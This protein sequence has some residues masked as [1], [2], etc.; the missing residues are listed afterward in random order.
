MAVVQARMTNQ[1]SLCAA[2]Q[3]VRGRFFVIDKFTVGTGTIGCDPETLLPLVPD[4]TLVYW[5]SQTSDSLF[6]I[7]S[8]YAPYSVGTDTVVI[9]VPV[10]DQFQNRQ[11]S[12]VGLYGTYVYCMD[13]G[14]SALIG[15]SFLHSIAHFGLVTVPSDQIMVVNVRLNIR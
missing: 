4:P 8:G 13:P 9:Q 3:Y 6:V 10:P 12:G 7:G 5:P 2:D 14:D 1:G 15:T 11:V